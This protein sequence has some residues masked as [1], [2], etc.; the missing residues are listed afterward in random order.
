MRAIPY[1]IRPLP[2]GGVQV[3]WK[4]PHA[5]LEVDISPEGRYGYLLITNPGNN[6]TYEEDNDVSLD[7]IIALISQ[8][9]RQ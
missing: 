5:E 9:L 3:V 6:P 2:A 1:D 8:T 4:G 7:T